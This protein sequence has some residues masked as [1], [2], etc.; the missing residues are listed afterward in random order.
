[1][2]PESMCEI[3]WAAFHCHSTTE[4][5]VL[6][7]LWEQC[8]PQTR[9]RRPDVHCANAS[10]KRYPVETLL[11]CSASGRTLRTVG[12]AQQE[13]P[14]FAPFCG[15]L[16][17]RLLSPSM[18][19]SLLNFALPPWR[20]HKL[21]AALAILASLCGGGNTNAQSLSA[22]TAGVATAHD[23]VSF[24][25]LAA[26]SD[27]VAEPAA[28]STIRPT[29]RNSKRAFPGVNYKPSHNESKPRRATTTTS[30]ATL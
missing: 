3:E 30:S 14:L 8:R 17:S 6:F 11:A 23:V 19:N 22:A 29:L 28:Q 2:F 9:I 21:I 16:R 18:M 13:R 20:V 4:I 1:M 25:E 26:N 24:S 7:T 15:A 5:F 27:A 12:P 10:A